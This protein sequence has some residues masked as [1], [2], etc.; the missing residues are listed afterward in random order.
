MGPEVMSNNYAQQSVEIWQSAV[1]SARSRCGRSGPLRALTATLLLALFG[2]GAAAQTPDQA[3]TINREYSIKAAFLYHF[4]TYVEWPPQ[5]FPA[6]KKTPFVIGLYQSD[7]FGTALSQIAQTKT[8]DGHPI[9]VRLLK[10][11]DGIAQ[12]QILFVP[13]SATPEQQAAA[14]RATK[15]SLILVIGE[16]D[17][18]IERG[19]NAQFFLEGNKVRFAFSAELSKREDLKVSSKLL[20][21]AKIVPKK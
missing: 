9:E 21:L 18:F 17:D 7:P 4:A 16:A 8:V 5:A 20:S 19:G 10:S 13:K 15:N 2:H 3:V 11:T 6:E 12:C 14:L 1:R